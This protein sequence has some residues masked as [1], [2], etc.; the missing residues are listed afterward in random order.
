MNNR[1]YFY[2]STNI[3]DDVN[4]D[5]F[6]DPVHVNDEGARLYCDKLSKQLKLA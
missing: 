2:D 3:Y 5:I 1:N 4:A 6:L